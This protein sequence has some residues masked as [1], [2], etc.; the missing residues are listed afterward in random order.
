MLKITTVVVFLIASL[1]APARA[2]LADG[3]AD[4][5]LGDAGFGT[6]F[7]GSPNGSSLGNN[8]YWVGVDAVTDQLIVTDSHNR[9]LIWNHP[10][11]L[12]NGATANIVLGQAD[13]TSV[14]TN[15]GG[16]PSAAT[17]QGICSAVVD[18]AGGLWAADCANNRVLHYTPPFTNGMNADKVLGQ[19]D[20]TSIG[21]STTASGFS[22]PQGLRF[23]GAGN[24][25]I[26]D[27]NND[28][29][30]RFAPPFSN[31][32]SANLVIGA[33]NF[34]TVGS[35]NNCSTCT[36]NPES[37]L[38]FDASGNLWYADGS[39]NRVMRFS[40][41]FTN[42]MAANLV[43]GQQNF[44][45]SLSFSALPGSN[46]TANS[47]S[48]PGDA[49][50]DGAGSLWVSDY[51]DNRIVRYDPP[52]SNGMAA[53]YVLGQPSFLTRYSSLASTS[54]G[55]P[56][57]INFDAAGNLW[58]TDNANARILRFNA[59]K[60]TATVGSGATTVSFTQPQGQI[61]VNAPAGAFAASTVITVQTPASFAAAHSAAATLTGAGFG[62]QVDAGG[63]QPASPVTITIAY[64]TTDV[65]GLTETRLVIAR[66][67]ATE[68]VW[69]P[70]PST[71]NT[72][73]HT[74]T[75]TT[76][77]FSTFQVMQ[78][79]PAA[80]VATGKVFPNPFRPAMGHTNV[81]FS[82]LPAS[83]SLKIYTLTGEKVRELTAS[84]AGV[85]TWD[86]NNEN[87]HGAAS[88]VYF[89]YAKAPNGGGTKTF[90]VAV[91]R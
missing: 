45:D 55:G 20:F 36:A 11:A 35:T 63:S 53:S 47:L 82:N 85:A 57:N 67:D 13:F 68:G 77:H 22:N 52:F 66:Y 26:T 4:L 60:N 59:A 3:K 12:T 29:V 19:G 72:T 46:P 14:S 70:L 18:S 10:A 58:T 48:Q 88:G 8:I 50:V 31:G 44:T 73:A 83:T 32:Q 51:D 69:V 37:G 56:W 9:I 39:A 74:V 2:D 90:K 1:A 81:T 75:A 38:S 6:T 79:T 15:R 65:T 84:A 21:A 27:Y 42:N 25:W 86:G 54:T 7:S 30:L 34:T 28:R 62:A 91:Q 80:A 16:S 89:V 23:D 76:N 43:L 17:L 78:V 49:I 64:R 24:L 71:V 61:T 40:P 33:P 87:G 5:V 41:P